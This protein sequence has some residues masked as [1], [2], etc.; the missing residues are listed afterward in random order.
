MTSTAKTRT[1]TIAA[2]AG[3]LGL[4]LGPA[5][6]Q[7]VRFAE[8]IAPLLFRAC[9]SCHQ[10][11]GSGPF[12][13]L[14]YEDARRH[15]RTIAAV[16]AS[17]FMPPWKP[18]PAHGHFRGQR[19]LSDHEVG[20]FKAWADQGFLRGDARRLPEAPIRQ[21]SWELGEPDL[22]L[23][24]PPYR[25][26]AEQPD[27]FRN[28]VIPVETGVMRYVRAWEFRP[29]NAT[30]VHHATVQIDPTRSSR[31][32]DQQDPTP[33]YE[34]L[35]APSARAPDG[36]FLDW[37]PGHGP[38]MA[39]PGTAWPLPDASD[40]LMML[41]LRPSGKEE[42]VQASI[43]LYFADGPPDQSPVMVRLT[44]QDL[45]I[46]AGASAHVV[47]RSYTVP[48]DVYAYSVLPHA[49]YLAHEISA[50]ASL[51]DGTRATLISIKEWDFN[52]Q[53]V[54]YFASPLLLP[55]GTLIEMR[56]TYNNSAS[57]FR[58]PSNPPRPVTYGQQT[59]DEMAELW[60]QVLPRN[61]ADRGSLL[62]SVYATTLPE[63]ISGRRMML[64][65]DG[66]NVALLDDLAVLLAETGDY[67]GAATV[68]QTS[69]RLQP[70]S[71]AARFNVASALLE[72]GRTPEARLYLEA[73][74]RADPSHAL[75]LYR[76][77]LVLKSQGETR[78]AIDHLRRAVSVTPRSL[79]AAAALAWMLAVDN[80][81]S[82]DEHLEAVRLAERIVQATGGKNA[83][84][85]DILATAL[86]ASGEF[87]GAVLTEDA[88][89]DLA[90]RDA[91][92]LE[93]TSMRKRLELFKQRTRYTEP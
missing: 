39:I 41:H 52:W 30:V 1:F 9:A 35:I 84:F 61:T 13:L 4:T 45:D 33:G 3:A 6:A 77:A 28:F 74:L 60:L 25:L 71:A 38:G 59:S 43:G 40:L 12:S 66:T 73:A 31:R 70:D 46:P 81:A 47:T 21:S 54:Y 51:P 32:F 91:Q 5:E 50:S 69:L 90:G 55:A 64:R 57:N 48:V 37:A 86:A 36:F 53:E 79:E 26:R 27:M 76:L 14:T 2:F 24:I 72:T 49:H 89:L 17:R 20:L 18:D 22:I 82:G 15:G 56:Y 65:R 7:N 85:L 80:Q 11:G 92:T 75:A 44:A 63:E 16:T 23:S 19:R 34:G 68:F 29:G 8:D 67:E 93:V 83:G 62:K 58:N 88:A 42:T 78:G 87:E 10:P